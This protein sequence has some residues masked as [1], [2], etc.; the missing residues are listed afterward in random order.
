MEKENVIWDFSEQF[1]HYYTDIHHIKIET[2][3]DSLLFRF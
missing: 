3:K 2:V 1:F